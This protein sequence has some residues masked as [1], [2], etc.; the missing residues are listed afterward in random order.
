M[1]KAY[2]GEIELIWSPAERLDLLAGISFIDS[3]IDEVPTV[4]NFFG[5]VLPLQ[6]IEDNELPNAP[7]FSINVLARYAW[8]FAGGEMAFQVDGNYNDDQYLD[9]FNSAA[10]REDAYFIGNLR[11]S[12]TTGDGKVEPDGI[13][14]EF[15]RC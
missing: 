11:L 15:Y 13:R 6:Q 14:Q 5:I 2:G 1:P 10:S 12:Y 7:S 8:P 9:V 3:E 4:Q